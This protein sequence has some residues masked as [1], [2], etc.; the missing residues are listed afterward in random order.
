MRAFLILPLLL[1][2]AS[3]AALV[4]ADVKAA[5]TVC[6]VT[7]RA[8]DPAIPPVIITVGKGERAQKIVIGVA[9]AA[10]AEKVKADPEAYVT[11]A[12]ANRR[13]ER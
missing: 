1:A 8:V 10:S 13:A 9:D 4:A 7:G 3:P 12:K 6:P 2:L 11:A 5:N